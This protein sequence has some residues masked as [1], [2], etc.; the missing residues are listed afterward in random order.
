VLCLDSA[1]TTNGG[2]A[3]LDRVDHVNHSLQ[4]TLRCAGRLCGSRGS[5]G[6]SERPKSTV[7]SF[8]SGYTTNFERNGVHIADL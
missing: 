1:A 3:G 7:A 8:C 4:N 5:T 6:L 2:Y